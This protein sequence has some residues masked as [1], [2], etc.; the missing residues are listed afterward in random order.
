MKNK[1]T[2]KKVKCKR[3]TF[4][5]KAFN[6]IKKTRNQ[7]KPFPVLCKLCLKKKYVCTVQESMALSLVPFDISC[8]MK[9]LICVL[10][11][12]IWGSVFDFA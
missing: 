12:I 11:V 5:S 1:S 2:K 10:M 7:M 9:Q 3:N 8:T 4:S 6:L